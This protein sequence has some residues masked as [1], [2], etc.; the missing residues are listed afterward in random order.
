MGQVKISPPYKD[1][2]LV[3]IS[4]AG[5]GSVARLRMV[6]SRLLLESYG[7]RSTAQAAR[8]SKWCCSAY[9]ISELGAHVLSFGHQSMRDSRGRQIVRR[10][11]SPWPPCLGSPP[12]ILN[13][14]SIQ[15]SF[16]NDRCRLLMRVCLLF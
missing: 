12:Q 11:P 3:A 16:K 10:Q 9:R 1:E 15:R 2:D 6:V 5:Q 8:C 14:L 7:P 4:E 13:A